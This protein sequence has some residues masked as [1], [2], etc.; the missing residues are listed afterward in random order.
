VADETIRRRKMLL[1]RVNRHAIGGG[2]QDVY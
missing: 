2:A 1:A